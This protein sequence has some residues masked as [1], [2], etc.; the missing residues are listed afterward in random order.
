MRHLKLAFYWVLLLIAQISQIGLIVKWCDKCLRVSCHFCG[1]NFRDWLFYINLAKF[2]VQSFRLL[3][4]YMTL[5]VL[6]VY[7]LVVHFAFL[8]YKV[9]YFLSDRCLGLG[10]CC[11]CWIVITT[12]F[13]GILWTFFSL[14]VA[15]FRCL[16]L[17]HCWKL[18]EI[19]IWNI[20]ARSLM[21]CCLSC[22]W[23]LAPSRCN[24]FSILLCSWV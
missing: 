21:E 18:G 9:A 10:I 5:I 6:K 2:S 12:L 13:L 1:E 4:L 22:C 17:A 23:R 3:A 24:I 14:D 11:S 8:T 20:W 16:T 15:Y 7:V 19:I